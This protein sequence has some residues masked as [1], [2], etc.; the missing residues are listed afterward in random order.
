MKR[1]FA[2]LMILLLG[3]VSLAL[4]VPKVPPKTPSTPP[5][6]PSVPGAAADTFDG[7]I[8]KARFVHGLG[9]AS[10]T[11]LGLVV[12]GSDGKEMTFYLRENSVMTDA[13]GTV[14]SSGDRPRLLKE[15][16][17][18]KYAVITDATGN[19]DK[20]EN[21]KNGVVSMHL[22]DWTVGS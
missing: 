4:G 15:N 20:I 19:L 12:T 16:V 9:W 6:V 18:I 1:T 3:G 2:A 10:K 7:R 14:L 22:L 13:N 21:G 8:D 11:D 5:P 17:E